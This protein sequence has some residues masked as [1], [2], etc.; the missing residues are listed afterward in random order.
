[1]ASKDLLEA[2][3]KKLSDTATVIASAYVK[4]YTNDN[5]NNCWRDSKLAG[6]LVL[7]VERSLQTILLRL[8]SVSKLDMVFETELY[9]N[10]ITFYNRLT[11]TFCAFPVPGGQ[12][13]LSFSDKSAAATFN[14]QLF[15]YSP[16]D[17]P[18][19]RHSEASVEV[20]LDGW[21]DKLKHRL[22]RGR[23]P[24]KQRIE[25]SKPYAVQ[26]V[27]RV[28][29]DPQSG[30]Y[31]LDSLPASLRQIFSHDPK[32]RSGD[33][34][35]STHSA[36]SKNNTLEIRDFS[37][38]NSRNAPERFTIATKA[39]KVNTFEEL[40]EIILGSRK[41][42]LVDNYA[43]LSI[44]QKAAKRNTEVDFTNRLDDDRKS[45]ARSSIS[46]ENWSEQNSDE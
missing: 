44:R 31:V 1:M 41:P 23:A 30:K 29:L 5:K 46:E 15:V 38:N 42:T 9:F 17:Q 6:V 43:H 18:S 39:A 32:L 13:G 3:D 35:L 20:P 33:V 34:S 45:K 14:R 12:L 11:D 7:L 28:E 4:L 27:S 8:Y 40:E 24:A 25:I 26:L 10:F 22:E 36:R 19:S 2:I 16:V 21:L 37:R